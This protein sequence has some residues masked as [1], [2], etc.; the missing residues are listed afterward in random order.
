MYFVSNIRLAVHKDF[1]AHACGE[2]LI[3]E[4]AS[5]GYSL[6]PAA[7]AMARFQANQRSPTASK[8]RRRSHYDFIDDEAEE[9]E[10]SI[11]SSSEFSAE[12]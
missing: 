11:S 2:S 3:R 6:P 8:R 9:S 10:A 4:S 12:P 7:S 1:G 5:C